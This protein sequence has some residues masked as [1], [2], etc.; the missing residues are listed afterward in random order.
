MVRRLDTWREPGGDAPAT[1]VIEDWLV[2]LEPRIRVGDSDRHQISQELRAHLNERVRDLILGGAPASIAERQALDELGDP[3]DLAR[4]F[5]HAHRH[6]TRKRLMNLTF[7]AIG[8]GA[9]SVGVMTI[10][11]ADQSE[12]PASIFEA[13]ALSE[14]LEQ[15]LST[16]INAQFTEATLDQAVAFIAE[17]IDR[18]LLIRW[19]E[20][21][22]F[23]VEP[24]DPLI[25]LAVEGVPAR[26][27]MELVRESID[28]HDDLRWTLDDELIE[29]GSA[30][31]ADIRRQ[32]F[33]SYDIEGVLEHLSLYTDWDSGLEQLT[34]L[35][36]NMV[37]PEAWEAN[38]GRSAHLSLVGPRMFV[39]AP[40]RIHREIACI[41][42]DLAPVEDDDRAALPAVSTPDGG[43]V[44]T[45]A[46]FEIGDE[47]TV[48]VFELMVPGEWYSVR[49]RI[50]A[51][52][53]LRLPHLAPVPAAGRTRIE[54]EAEIVEAL[55]V[56]ITS[57]I[58]QVL[59]PGESAGPVRP[60][61]MVAR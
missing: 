44:D 31:D 50:D 60:E 37:E 7:I 8:A 5:R 58:A 46:A 36:H 1:C 25:S 52:G 27:V 19:D 20:V 9:L 26:R 47:L 54:L 22:D 24:D 42:A 30:E 33:A 59:L 21:V 10:G 43:T 55:S 41:L 6:A 61:T 38:G 12:V 14:A 3:G 15:P 2:D 51:D 35:I 23:G 11:G 17:A 29:L 53:N 13:P 16:P 18:P 56:V 28:T 40:P 32:R 45:A 39:K 48:Q 34:S 49:R 4:R 57:P